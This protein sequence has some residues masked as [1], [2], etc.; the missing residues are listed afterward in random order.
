V[1]AVVQVDMVE[2]AVLVVLELRAQD[3]ALLVHRV[4]AAVVLMLPQAVVV[5]DC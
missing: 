4:L 2:Q 3:L 1:V 5:L